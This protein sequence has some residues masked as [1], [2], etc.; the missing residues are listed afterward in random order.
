MD[1]ELHARLKAGVEAANQGRTKD[2]G[3][4][5]QYAEEPAWRAELRQQIRAALGNV[6]GYEQ[7]WFEPH[8]YQEGAAAVLLLLDSHIQAAEQ[9]G[10]EAALRSFICGVCGHAVGWI[11]SPTGGWWAHEVHPSDDHDA[12]D[13]VPDSDT[14]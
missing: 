10:R 1:E 4:F 12:T 5:A 2:L 3:D 8:D 13:C 11:N 9:R 6:D 7:E 14:P